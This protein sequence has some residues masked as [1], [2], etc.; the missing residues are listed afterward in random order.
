M[1]TFLEFLME[2]PED[3]EKFLGSP[4]DAEVPEKTNAETIPLGQDLPD[5]T[6]AETDDNSFIVPSTDT[7]KYFA[8][9]LGTKLLTI[10]NGA[11]ED[12]GL[13]KVM[14]DMN[15]KYFEIESKSENSTEIEKIRSEV[16]KY[17]N[18][19]KKDTERMTKFL[20]PENKK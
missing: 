5:E 17:V 16:T 3:L 18:R 9:F 8:Y 11:F 4:E 14:K 19:F 2:S 20:F 13:K 15:K 6:D 7:Q 10:L 1:M 12:D